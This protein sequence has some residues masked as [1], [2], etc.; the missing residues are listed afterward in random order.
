[1]DQ[2]TCK[3]GDKERPC[4]SQYKEEKGQQ[5]RETLA[6]RR[7]DVT[8][9]VDPKI[10]RNWGDWRKELDGMSGNVTPVG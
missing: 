7:E 6:D 9:R 10:P 4:E 1:V 5:K 8:R 2:N 3:V